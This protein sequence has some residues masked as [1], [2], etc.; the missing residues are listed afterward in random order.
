MLSACTFGPIEYVT[1][2][3]EPQIQNSLPPGDAGEVIVPQ[4]GKTLY[5]SV[6]D[7][8]LDYVSYTWSLDG[9]GR[10][11]EGTTEGRVYDVDGYPIEE[12]NVFYLEANSFYDGQVL[13]W[14]IRD[15]DTGLGDDLRD[16]TLTYNWTVVVP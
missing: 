1:V 13:T 7:D 5:V 15:A 14:E 11:G 3:L 16:F 8:D 9:T 12:A 10:L 6:K 4:G 2:N